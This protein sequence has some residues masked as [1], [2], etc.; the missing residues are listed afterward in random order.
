MQLVERPDGVI[1]LHPHVPVPA[2]QAWFWTHEWQAGE[3]E[4]S[5]QITRGDVTVHDADDFVDALDAL[6]ALVDE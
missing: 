5:E 2:D 3:Q 6:D 1:E 4:A